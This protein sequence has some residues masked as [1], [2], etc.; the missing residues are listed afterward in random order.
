MAWM[1]FC[2][3]L[4]VVDSRWDLTVEGEGAII[5]E[6]GEAKCEREPTNLMLGVWNLNF[7]RRFISTIIVRWNYNKIRDH[8]M[9]DVMTLEKSS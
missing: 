6:T 9:L 3:M 7:R 8:H 4:L 2:E 1:A 5:Y